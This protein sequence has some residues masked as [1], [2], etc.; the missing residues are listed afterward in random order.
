MT[1]LFLVLLF[2]T[3]PVWPL[4]VVVIWEWL[5]DDPIR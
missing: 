3:A 2:A 1:G 5:L 4:M